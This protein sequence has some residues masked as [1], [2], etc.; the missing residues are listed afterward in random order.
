MNAMDCRTSVSKLYCAPMLCTVHIQL[1]PIDFLKQ[2]HEKRIK[3]RPS[4]QLQAV[5]IF[6]DLYN[7]RYMTG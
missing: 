7:A 2:S 1:P 3:I 6:R 4:G 5:H